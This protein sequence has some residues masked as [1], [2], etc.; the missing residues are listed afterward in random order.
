MANGDTDSHSNQTVNGQ[1]I[2]YIF[3][4]RGGGIRRMDAT[5]GRVKW[6]GDHPL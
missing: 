4:K 6:L 2:D 1:T 5:L 3:T